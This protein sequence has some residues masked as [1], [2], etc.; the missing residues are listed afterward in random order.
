MNASADSADITETVYLLNLETGE[1]TPV[2]TA[3]ANASPAYNLYDGYDYTKILYQASLDL[4]TVAPGN[5]S[6]K[7]RVTNGSTTQDA[8]LAYGM[9]LA[10]CLEEDMKRFRRGMIAVADD[11]A[12]DIVKAERC[13]D[14][15][16]RAVIERGHAARP[17]VKKCNCLNQNIPQNSH[18][19]HETQMK[20]YY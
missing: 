1:E 15:P 12:V 19:A 20:K 5:Y 2:Q 6:V 9:I 3:T 14:K 11:F 16:V 17:P 18:V 8:V 13:A 7:I 4:E 10:L